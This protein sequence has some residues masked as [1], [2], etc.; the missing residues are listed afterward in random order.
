M[1]RESSLILNEM[2]VVEHFDVKEERGKSYKMQ[3]PQVVRVIPQ[4]SQ[5]HWQIP[6][7]QRCCQ[8]PRSSIAPKIQSIKFRVNQTHTGI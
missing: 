1:V 3:I 2:M 6:R 8:Q 7:F 4:I 5:R